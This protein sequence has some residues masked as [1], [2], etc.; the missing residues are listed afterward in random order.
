MQES[1]LCGG[2][3]NLPCI[4][5]AA[6]AAVQEI[7]G[8]VNVCGE[9]QYV[10]VGNKDIDAFRFV[11]PDPDGNGLAQVAIE[12]AAKAP[13]FIAL[14]Q[15]PCAPLAQAPLKAQVSG[16]VP[17]TTIECLPP[18]T[19][20]AIVAKGTFPNTQEF[21]EPCG[22]AQ[23]YV[24]R[25]SWTDQCV[26][27]CGGVGDCYGSHSTPGCSDATCCSTV[28]ATD[29]LCCEKTWDELCVESALT[30]CNPGAPANDAC[31]GAAPLSVGTHAYS[32]AGATSSPPA[33]PAGCLTLGGTAVG[34]D[35]W[36]SLADLQ[37]TVT[38]STCAGDSIDTV[39]VVYPDSCTAQPVAC[40]DDNP[41]CGSNSN[42]SL[43]SFSAQCG[44]TY[45]IRVASASAQ[46]GSG[47]ITVASSMPA[48]PACNADLNDDSVVDGL[49]LSV[50]LSG[51]G[52]PGQGDINHDGAVDGIDL[53]AILSGWGNCF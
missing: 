24:F 17:A 16:C 53:T 11:L 34:A 7:A 44:H 50:V 4:D 10:G 47:R 51:W 9:I 31:D 39:L 48:C 40:D 28:C 20:Y 13:A 6:N 32:L 25:I 27:P 2:D 19:W 18:G 46:A 3:E 42:S 45:F 22:A 23:K 5:G 30:L 14:T 37:G 52:G 1:E 26:N 15:N 33:V 36:F 43:V 8:G 38:V 29:P 12:F 49:D 41:E 35:V 21:S